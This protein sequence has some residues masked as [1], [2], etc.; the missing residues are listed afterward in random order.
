[1]KST[2]TP[3]FESMASTLAVLYLAIEL[4]VQKW[5]LLFGDGEHRRYRTIEAR[6]MVSL[7]SEIR[8]SKEKLKLPSDA[9]VVSCFEAGRDGHWLHRALCAQ[10]IHNLEVTSTSI[11]VNQQGKHRKTDRLDLDSLY[12]QLIH[13]TQGERDELQ[14]V[15][16]P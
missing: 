7:L 10:G 16:V 6:D 14:V 13:Y 5:H 3:L 1:M 8:L 12:I 2:Q 9:L 11:K 15:N 4:G